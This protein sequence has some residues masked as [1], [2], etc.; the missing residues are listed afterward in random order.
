AGRVG[1]PLRRHPTQGLGRQPN[2]GWRASAVGADVG[3]AD[4]LAAGPLSRGLPESTPAG[5]ARGPVLASV[6]Y[7]VDSRIAKSLL[8]PRL[9]P[10]F[11]RQSHPSTPSSELFQDRL[12]HT[13]YNCYRQNP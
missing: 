4:L 10:G 11:T 1:D 3:L 5:H 8:G 13:R 2:L 12:P 7:R 6:T 9:P